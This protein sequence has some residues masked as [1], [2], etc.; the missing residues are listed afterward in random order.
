MANNDKKP[1]LNRSG[2]RDD[3]NN[4]RFNPKPPKKMGNLVLILLISFLF[5]IGISSYLGDSQFNQKTPVSYSQFE[6]LL[7]NKQIKSLKIVDDNQV[8]F[9]AGEGDTEVVNTTVL[10]IIFDND[11]ELAGLIRESGAEILGEKKQPSTLSLI[12]SSLPWIIAIFFFFAIFRQMQGGGAKNFTRSNAKKVDLQKTKVTFADVAGQKEA[13]EELSEIVDFLKYPKRYLSLGAKIPK[14]VLLTGPPGTGKTLL[15]RAV[16]GEAN[17]N[18]FHMSGSDFVEVFVGVGAG[19]VRDLFE[20]AKKNSPSIIF[21]DELDAVGRQRS[22]GAGVGGSHD[23][24]EQT[25]NQMLVEMDGFDNDTNVIVMAATNRADVLDQALLRPGRFDRRVMVS[26]PDVQERIEILKLHA[27]KIK[28]DQSG[29]L[30][31]EA[32]A[33]GSVGFSGADLANVVNEA[34][35][36]AARRNA[37]EVSEQDFE[38]ARD[39]TMLGA[40]RKSL[41][42]SLDEKRQTAYHEAGHALLHYLVKDSD[43]LHKVTIVPRSRALGIAFSLPKTDR[44]SFNKNQL[45]ARIKIAYGGYAAEQLIYGWT[46]AGVQSDLQQATRLARKMVTEWGMSE[47]LGPIFLGEEESYGMGFDFGSKAPYSQSIALV[48]DEE[49]NKILFSCLEEVQTLL[50]DNKDQLEKLTEALLASETLS[51]K[52]IRVLL[53]YPQEEETEIEKVEESVESKTLPMD[54]NWF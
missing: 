43:P 36:L 8:E 33:R 42:M 48:I 10:P 35:L 18:F 29:S 52:E 25:L 40:A 39:K 13:K 41:A 51:D 7:K 20:Q 30:D 2:K 19:R 37:K 6:L 54:K 24:R 47:K 17:V 50:R 16:A 23:E 21:I 32:I 4:R 44:F 15:A 45:L 49:I 46:T 27:S 34:A 1:S 14:G 3:K 11:P 22:R 31:L 26:L 53:D 5:L 28:I 38:E 12:L 9:T